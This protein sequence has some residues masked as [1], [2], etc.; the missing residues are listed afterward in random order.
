MNEYDKHILII[1]LSAMGDVAIAAPLILALSKQ[2]P[3][4]KITVLTKPFF[5][6][7]FDLIPNVEVLNLKANKEHKGLIGLYKLSQQIK[8]LKVDAIA[9]LHNVLRTKII[10]V[11]LP[12]KIRFE[13]INKGRNEKKQLVEGKLFKQLPTSFDRY[14]NVFNSLNIDIS[15]EQPYFLEKPTIS[16]DPVS[17][18]FSSSKKT[19]GIAP[20]AAFEGKTYPLTKMKEVVNA[21]SKNYLVL[22]FGGKN[23]SEELEELVTNANVKNCAGQFSFSDELAIIAHL[24]L[25]ISMDSGNAHLA[26]MF[27]VKTVTLWG[28]THPFAGFYPYKQPM[29]YALLANREK[30]PKIPTS[31]YGNKSPEDYVNAIASIA[32]EE[33]INKVS[34]VIND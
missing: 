6:P 31:I 26:A 4:Y 32:P 19:I 14:R 34:Q 18:V 21:L 23:Q 20:F 7:I 8:H 3:N 24:D 33:I 13:K 10:S 11:F 5:N 25:M 15:L 22:L 30:Y 16:S 17:K 12:S 29:E 9:D 1:R 27:G 2:Y 28:I